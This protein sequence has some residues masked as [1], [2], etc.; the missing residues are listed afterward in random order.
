M[1]P[2][3]EARPN[4]D[5]LICTVGLPLS[6]KTT[7]AKEQRFPIVNP[8][9]IRLELYGQRYWQA[10]EQMVWAI[11]NLMVRALFRA[12]HQ[13]VILDA[14]NITRKRRD[15]WISEAWDTRFHR[16]T[17]DVSVCLERARG[18]GDKKIV[19]VIEQKQK[20]SEDL[21]PDEIVWGPG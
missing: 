3:M 1:T 6:G 13:H 8:D 16:I 9:A 7:W 12:G 18:A 20:D 11:T 2:P 19:P 10:G 15:A 14:T 17:I 4:R 5:T 21:A